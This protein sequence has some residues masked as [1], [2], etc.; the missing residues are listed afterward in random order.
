[1][2]WITP[3]IGLCRRIGVA[4]LWLATT[5]AVQT[6]H[7]G[8]VLSDHAVT[9]VVSTMCEAMLPAY[10]QGGFGFRISPEGDWL[11][12]PAP[13]GRTSS[14]RLLPSERQALQM[15]VRRVLNTLPASSYECHVRPR[16]PG[17][18]EMVA[19]TT[20]RQALVFRGAGGQLEPGCTP[21]D[22]RADAA[23]FALVDRLMR[24]YY[25]RPF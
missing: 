22:A 17:V 8:A 13:D 19:I 10:C 20:D 14:G 5:I 25:P 16:I 6:L 2:N 9:V 24:R 4:A 21:G 11:A 3:W 18:G 12:G 15:A 7:V 1:M 23:L